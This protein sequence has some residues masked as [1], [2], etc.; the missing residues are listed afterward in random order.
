MGRAQES[1]DALGELRQVVPAA[2]IRGILLLFLRATPARAAVEIRNHL[3]S[4]LNE[5]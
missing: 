1:F 3:A 4:F 2:P 5:A